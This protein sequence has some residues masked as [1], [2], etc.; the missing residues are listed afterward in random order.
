MGHQLCPGSLGLL[1]KAY[2]KHIN[3]SSA[4]DLAMLIAELP[5]VQ[6]QQAVVKQLQ[7]VPIANVVRVFLGELTNKSKVQGASVA[8]IVTVLR[9]LSALQEPGMPGQLQCL[10]DAF[11]AQLSQGSHIDTAEGS[12]TSNNKASITSSSSGSTGGFGVS[13]VQANY[14][15]DVLYALASLKYSVSANQLHLLLDAGAQ[16]LKA[17]GGQEAVSSMLHAAGSLRGQVEDE[18]VQQLLDEFLVEVATSSSNNSN[19]YKKA[20]SNNAGDG[21]RSWLQE[22]VGTFIEHGALHQVELKD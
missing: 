21:G 19:A 15:A 14:V 7:A 13:G 20:F 2:T 11:L 22:K 5:L 8:E 3:R 6:Q 18:K 1:L 4:T 12:N 17:A 10:L 16:L 9:S